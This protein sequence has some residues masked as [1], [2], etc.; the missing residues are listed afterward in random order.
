MLLFRKHVFHHN[1]HH[2]YFVKSFVTAAS[3]STSQVSI[4]REVY[5]QGLFCNYGASSIDL[6]NKNFSILQTAI[7]NREEPLNVA[8]LTLTRKTLLLN[9]FASNAS[10]F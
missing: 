2:L 9:P 3:W 6:I 1:Y 8:D 4:E 10:F 5:L 7:Q